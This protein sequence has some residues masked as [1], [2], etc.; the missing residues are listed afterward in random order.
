V[1][2]SRRSG[3]L[4]ITPRSGI[5]GLHYNGY[6][7]SSTFDLT[8]KQASVEVV[9]A[10]AS[11]ANT[12]FALVSDGDNWFRFVAE[13]GTLYF[14]SNISGVKAS[15]NTSYNA[16]QHRFWRFRHDSASKLMFWETISDGKQW[17]VKHAA[18]A[19]IP[20]TGLYVE[21]NAGTYQPVAGPGTA[22][23]DNFRIVSL[24]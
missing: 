10:A 24:D 2:V 13:N 4:E 11:T 3:R 8:G 20:V 6:V 19:Q 16:F 5:S 9:Q 23:F 14:Q 7:S 1:S 12:V 17:T 18:T 22:V 15:A 21:L